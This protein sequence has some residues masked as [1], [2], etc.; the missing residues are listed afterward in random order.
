[1]ERI[2]CIVLV[3]LAVMMLGKLRFQKDMWWLI[4]KNWQEKNV[5]G[6]GVI[7]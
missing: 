3:M 7:Y 1:M 6:Q 4:I 2:N 5:R